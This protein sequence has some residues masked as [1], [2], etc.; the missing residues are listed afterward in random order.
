[1]LEQLVEP[2]PL[3]LG[4]EDQVHDSNHERQ[5]NLHEIV[6]VV[7]EQLELKDCDVANELPA[8]VRI[9]VRSELGPCVGHRASAQNLT[10]SA[11]Q[12]NFIRG[13]AA[14]NASVT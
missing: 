6:D 13:A 5:G 10:P 2:R 1:M 3:W 12:R 14:E 9:D 4:L 11:P 8:R 7:E